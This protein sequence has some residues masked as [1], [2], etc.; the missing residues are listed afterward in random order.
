MNNHIKELD[1]LRGIAVLL[2]IFFHLFLRAI[3]FTQVP[4]LKIFAAFTSVGWA[5]VD[6]FFT[7]SGFLITSILLKTKSRENYFK[8][9]YIRRILRIFPL[10]YAAIILVLL[11]I[12]NLE[13]EFINSRGRTLSLML[14]YQQNW[15]PL[16]KNY[17]MTLYLSATWSLAIEEQ[18]YFLWPFIVYKLNREQLLGLGTGYIVLSILARIVGIAFWPN[19]AQ[20]ALFFYYAPFARFE[21]ILFGSLL[22]VLLTFQRIE[23]RIRLFSIPLSLLSLAAFISLCFLSLPGSPSPQESIPLTIGGYT[24]IAVFAAGLIGVFV[25][26]SPENILRRIF[27]T[28]VLTFFGKYSYSM[29]LFHMVPVLLLA[30]TFWYSGM[31]SWASFVMYVV[32]TFLITILIALLTWNL[33]EKH[34]L[35]LKK[36]FE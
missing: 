3:F 17:S 25:T 20:A 29:Y 13:P 7:L 9:F 27:K 6:I 22:A 4:I 8:N 1:G 12:P 16:L 23:Q 34:M 19:L 10:Y 35:N 28:S 31:H 36:Y 2:V 33:L 5:G 21:E 26:S 32:A 14:L 11:F 18:F 15:I 24:T 30:H